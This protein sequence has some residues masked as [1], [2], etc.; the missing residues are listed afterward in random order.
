MKIAFDEKAKEDDRIKS[1]VTEFLDQVETLERKM[2]TPV[3]IFQ[4]GK[5]LA[6]YIKCSISRIIF[7]L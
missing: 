1:V 3:L 7:V 5:N 6:Y 4:D 2:S